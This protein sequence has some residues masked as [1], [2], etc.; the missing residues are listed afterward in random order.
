MASHNLFLYA[1]TYAD[2]SAARN[3]LAVV[4]DLHTLG[5]IG[6]YDSA[7]IT[8]EPDGKVAVSKD[9]MATRHGGWGGLAV[10]ALVG[11]LFPPSIAASAAVGAAVGGVGGHLWRG[12][13]RSDLKDIGEMLDEGES[14]LVVVGQDKIRDALDKAELHAQKELKRELD[15]DADE[16]D[17]E[18][19]SALG[20]SG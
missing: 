6:S 9:E 15:M 8:K 10:G 2:E 3:D 13:S 17:A 14:A 20:T 19:R 5:G 12:L 7:V 4:K 1:G 18:V 11:I 16:F